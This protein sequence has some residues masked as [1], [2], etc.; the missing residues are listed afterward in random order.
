[1]KK[2]R[3]F[4]G[5]ASWLI[6]TIT[7]AAITI[8]A[9]RTLA[10]ELISLSGSAHSVGVTAVSSSET[11]VLLWLPAWELRVYFRTFSPF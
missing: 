7:C 5:V 11:R 9:D 3:C 2:Q 4:F 10:G 8:E 1:M 6:L